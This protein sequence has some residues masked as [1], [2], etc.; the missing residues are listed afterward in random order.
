M[1]RYIIRR[2]NKLG[3]WT[4]IDTIE[5]LPLLYTWDSYLKNRYGPGH[6]S[7]LV[8]Q[9]GVRGLSPLKGHETTFSIG[10]ENKYLDWLDHK[11]TWEELVEK[12]GVGDYIVAKLTDVEPFGFEREK[13]DSNVI[14][15]ILEQGA[16]AARGG[17]VVFKLKD[18]PYE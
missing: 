8:A 9:E 17:Y 12:Y 6:Y 15:D 4:H 10:W 11:P 18:I 14:R 3:Q 1:V 13:M 2:Q 16:S 7:I 5:S